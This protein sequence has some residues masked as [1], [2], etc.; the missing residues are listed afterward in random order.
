V[1]SLSQIL[2]GGLHTLTGSQV[3]FSYE[4]RCS[5]YCYSFKGIERLF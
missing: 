1:L 4:K 5:I 2:V 3:V